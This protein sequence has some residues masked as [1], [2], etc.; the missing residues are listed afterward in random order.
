MASGMTAARSTTVR[1]SRASDHRSRSRAKSD[2]AD[3]GQETLSSLARFGL[4]ARG[5]FYLMLVYLVAQLA[6]TGG[7]SGNGTGSGSGKQANAHG[8]LTTIAAHPGGLAAIAATAFG[9][10]AFGIAREWGAIRDEHPTLWHRG[11]TFVQGAFYLALT[12]V[13]VSYA[14]GNTSTG[15]EQQQHKTASGLLRLPGGRELLFAL[16]LIV[17]AVCVHQIW[18]GI[19][20]DYENGM[21]VEE[22]ARWVRAIVRAAGTIGIPARATVFLPTGIFFMIAAAQ[23]DPRHADGLDKE[24]SSLARHEWGIA[25]LGLVSLGLAIFAVY[26]FLEARYRAVTKGR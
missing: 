6:A 12:W 17:V 23:S 25:I 19:D 9:F 3:A 26:S 2:A 1:S 4:V 16:G 10:F 15:S 5:F 13:P 21:D 20:Q 8:A 7:G 11:M 14:L 24:L 18:N 22:S